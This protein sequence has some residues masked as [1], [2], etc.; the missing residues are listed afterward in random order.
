MGVDARQME[1][2]EKGVLHDKVNQ[3]L[4]HRSYKFAAKFTEIYDEIAKI[5]PIYARLKKL[6]KAIAMAQWIYLNKIPIDHQS[7]LEI[8]QKQKIQNYNE[9]VPSLRHEYKKV[10]RN[11]DD[12]GEITSTTSVFGGVDVQLPHADLIEDYMKENYTASTFEKG[13]KQIE[14]IAEQVEFINP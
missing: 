8:V 9:T 10:Y 1:Q 12:T 13:K 14:V 4:N 3:D 11:E 6:S 2:D 7:L 5:Y